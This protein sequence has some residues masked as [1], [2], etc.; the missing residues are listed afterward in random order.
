MRFVQKINGS[1][2]KVD[3]RNGE[4]S[5][6]GVFSRSSIQ[7]NISKTDDVGIVDA[8]PL[9]SILKSDQ[10][11][12]HIVSPISSEKQK[13]VPRKMKQLR[14][15]IGFSHKTEKQ[16]GLQKLGSIKSGDV[17]VMTQSSDDSSVMRI[18]SR[19]SSRDEN[20]GEGHNFYQLSIENFVRP[21]LDT[22]ESKENIQCVCPTMSEMVSTPRQFCTESNN[23]ESNSSP[24]SHNY[25]FNLFERN[26]SGIPITQS[27]QDQ[28]QKIVSNE[29][30][31][32]CSTFR[33]DI[34]TV[35]DELMAMENE[36]EAKKNSEEEGTVDAIVKGVL[37]RRISRH[38][39][40]CDQSYSDIS[41]I[42]PS[43]SDTDS[44][45]TSISL[46]SNQTTKISNR[47]IDN[48]NTMLFN[49]INENMQPDLS[50][51][52]TFEVDFNA[53]VENQNVDANH[54]AKPSH[55][56]EYLGITHEIKTVFKDILNSKYPNIASPIASTFSTSLLKS[57][58][59]NALK[60]AGF[61]NNDPQ[62]CI[63]NE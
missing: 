27:E 34:S 59:E 37:S 35:L 54:E 4:H 49:V 50:E 30:I 14:K 18:L 42:E 43:F 1:S 53:E 24:P 7:K 17:P 6:Y 23:W 44:I 2:K 32:P 3:N 10:D 48:K 56:K 5:N 60:Y 33:N 8:T 45:W 21:F 51:F 31:K 16:R 15:L 22:F 39:V 52:Q 46:S 40:I 41:D 58:L 38:T 36:I 57:N 20:F 25:G 62:S 13:I 61:I 55:G 29:D 9:L 28:G 11:L 26:D 47:K 12:E 19:D 63:G